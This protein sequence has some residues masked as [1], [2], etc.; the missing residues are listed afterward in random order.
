MEEEDFELTLFDRVEM[1]K[2]LVEKAGGASK[3]CVSFSGGKDSSVLSKL[4]DLALPD[5]YKTPCNFARTGCRGCPFDY[6]LQR[7]LEAMERHLP[8]DFKVANAIFGRVYEEYRKRGYR[9]LD[10]RDTDGLLF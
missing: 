8:K 2:K 3:V 5:V 4:I 1:T 10:K 9:L 7:D 6:N